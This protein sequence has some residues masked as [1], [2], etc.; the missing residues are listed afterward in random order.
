MRFKATKNNL[1]VQLAAN[2]VAALVRN[3]I[4]LLVPRHAT[5]VY[6]LADSE[7]LFVPNQ[8]GLVV[9][10]ADSEPSNFLQSFRL[11]LRADELVIVSPQQRRFTQSEWRSFAEAL[12]A[13][14]T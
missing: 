14:A 5:K 11:L 1:V 7:S 3:A 13:H 8:K 6:F 10:K 9:V 4:S 2:E 12:A